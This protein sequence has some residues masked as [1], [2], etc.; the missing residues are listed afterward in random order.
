[1]NVP[2]HAVLFLFS[3]KLSQLKFFAKSSWVQ[4]DTIKRDTILYLST[5]T[6]QVKGKLSASYVSINSYLTSNVAIF[7]FNTASSVKSFKLTHHFALMAARL[8]AF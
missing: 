1:V 3:A 2:V 8:D 6:V 5:L 7:Y 4:K